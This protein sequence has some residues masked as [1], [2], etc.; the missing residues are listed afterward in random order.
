LAADAVG[1][2]LTQVLTDGLAQ[3]D[4]VEHGQSTP[5]TVLQALGLVELTTGIAQGQ[6]QS[7]NALGV[8]AV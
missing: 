3:T 8:L 1:R 5:E 6:G 4:A 7:S 2:N